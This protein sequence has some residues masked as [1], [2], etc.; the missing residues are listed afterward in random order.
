MLQLNLPTFAAKVSL[1]NGKRVIFDE[2]RR[3]W[4]ALTPEEW[5]RQHFVHY[6]IDR[7]G[8]PSALVANEVAIRVE[9]TAKRC[10]TI[11]YGRSLEP[12]MIVEYKS[13]A[14]EITR[15]VFDQIARYDMALRVPYLAVSNGLRH[16][17]CR[18]DPAEAC[19]YRFVEELPAY[20]EL[21][22]AAGG[23]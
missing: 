5:V 9:K 22:S 2:V 15:A 14:V 13:A 23:Q 16:Y 17:C 12:L 18:I 4:V 3:R 11:V 8:Y 10:D 1:R 21:L 19:G 6:L 20:E 7:K